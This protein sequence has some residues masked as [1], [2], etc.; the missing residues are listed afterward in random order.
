MG[1]KPIVPAERLALTLRF[2]ATGETFQSLHFQF[3][4]SRPAISYNVTEVCEAVTKMLGPS[5][6][7]VP[8]SEQEW[9]QI[10]K[11]LEEKW[12]FVLQMTREA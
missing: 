10:A 6:L 12:I 7:K 11:Q 9:L 4:I 3:R 2:L 1:G 8:S 5:Y